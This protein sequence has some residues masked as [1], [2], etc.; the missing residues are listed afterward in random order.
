LRAIE[1]LKLAFLVDAE[2]NRLVGR[3]EVEPDNVDHFLS[4]FGIV[5]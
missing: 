3:V 2:H 4:E 5:R 1:R